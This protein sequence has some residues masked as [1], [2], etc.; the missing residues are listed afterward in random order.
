MVVI[1]GELQLT[2]LNSQ[3]LRQKIA[4]TLKAWVGE[5]KL[6]TTFG[7]PYRQEIF[8]SGV[9]K[10]ALDAIFLVKIN[11]FT[12]IEEIVAFESELDRTKRTYDI[13][14]LTVR[15]TEGE[16]VNI[17]AAAPDTD[18]VYSASPIQPVTAVCDG[19]ITVEQANELHQFLHFDLVG[20]L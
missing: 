1:N 7:I 19:F 11:T 10:Q 3:E 18:T 17:T 12:E 14:E 4:I 15:T 20:L 6:D 9:T 2:T 13:T 5:W 16:L 8:V